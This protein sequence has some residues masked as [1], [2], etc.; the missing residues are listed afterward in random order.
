MKNLLCVTGLHV[1]FETSTGAVRA[2]RG[3]NLTV[4]KQE[5]LGVMGESGCGKTVL[6]LSLMRLQQ[7]GVIAKGSIIFNGRD[8]T[9][10]SENQM[11]HIRGR[12]I[13]LIPQNHSTALNPVY[14]VGQQLGE[15]IGRRHGRTGLWQIIR[16]RQP[17]YGSPA[18]N[19]IKDL[20]NRMNFGDERFFKRLLDSYPHELS[21]GMRQRVL[22]GMAL[23]LEPQ[24]VIADEPTTALD[25]ATRLEILEL[26]GMLAGKTTLIVVSHEVDAIKSICNRVAVMYGGRVVEFG[27]TSAVL[28]SPKHPYT[29]L[30]L[31]SQQFKRGGS[32]SI[33]A[34]ALDMVTF[35]SGCPFYPLCPQVM[36]VCSQVEPAEV[37]TGEGVVACHLYHGGK[38]CWK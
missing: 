7:P 31:K 10:L 24:L 8:I 36:P 5:R 23:L 15:T 16:T 29:R 17:G 1:N 2:N 6:M 35:P 20:F 27:K 9:G 37:A 22:I 11:R 34:G 19:E 14:T 30:L 12:G 28:S 13:A 25:R 32:I 3:V 33:T 21:G 4:E 38:E 18:Y 26:L